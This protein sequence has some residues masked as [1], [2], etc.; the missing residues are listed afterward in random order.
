MRHLDC[1]RVS[2]CLEE[3]GLEPLG[4]EQVLTIVEWPEK[5]QN[6]QD[7]LSRHLELEFAESEKNLDR[8]CKFTKGFTEQEVENIRLLFSS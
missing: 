5:L 2:G 3:V 8:I 4:E 6:Y 7:L 1:F